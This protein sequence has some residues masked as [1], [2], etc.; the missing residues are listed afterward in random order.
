MANI[1]HIEFI[2]QGSRFWNKWREDNPEIEPDLKKA[3]LSGINATST[4][5]SKTDLSGARIINGRLCSLS[6]S[7]L[8]GANLLGSNIE[9]GELRGARLSGAVLR[10]V[11]LRSSDLREADL[12]NADLS[13][14]NLGASDLT[15][16]NLRSANL[17]GASLEWS[18]LEGAL[19]LDTNLEGTKLRGCR[20][21]GI[22]A[23]DIK[24]NSETEQSDLIISSDNNLVITVDNIEVAQFLYLLINNER[25]RYAI[26]SITSKVVLILGRFTD[27]RKFVLD[28]IRTDLRKSNYIPVLFD[29][30]K[31]NSRDLTETVSTLAHMARFIIADLTDPKSIPHELAT[32]VPTLSIPVQPLLEWNTTD[33]YAMFHDL[34]KYP[35][36]LK[37][38]RYK[39]V[40]ELLECLQ[41][42]IIAPAEATASKF[43]RK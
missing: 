7:N 23:W 4:N 1:D 43:W 27:E 14:A 9:Y 18:N 26:D 12:S 10:G 40:S 33:E 24:V 13:Y 22:S 20:V 6:Y 28:A 31:P 21:Y 36:V 16:A 11:N 5:L 15:G 29:F 39:N 25:L 17:S 41:D 8:S 35:W 3:H 2:K 37:I 34:M 32:I 38:F 19:L 30:D 42:K